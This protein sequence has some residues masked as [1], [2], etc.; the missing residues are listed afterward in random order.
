MP[1]L[2]QLC[3]EIIQVNNRVIGTLCFSGKV[4]A[5]LV[6]RGLRASLSKPS[7]SLLVLRA[8]SV[9]AEGEGRRK[10]EEQSPSQRSV[11]NPEG[12]PHQIPEHFELYKNRLLL[13]FTG[14]NICFFNDVFAAALP[15]RI[16]IKI[17]RSGRKKYSAMAVIKIESLTP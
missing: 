3:R 9:L 12:S 1:C 6:R 8:G 17:Q 2:F 14:D 15:K 11:S 16:V 10:G 13:L 7:W 4:A 5:E